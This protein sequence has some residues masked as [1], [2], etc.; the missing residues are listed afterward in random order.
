[1]EIQ[2]SEI[3]A[4][5]MNVVK[6]QIKYIVVIHVV[7]M[8]LFLKQITFEKI[9]LYC[10]YRSSCREI[11]S[12]SIKKKG[13]EYDTWLGSIFYKIKFLYYILVT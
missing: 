12:L 4:L 8:I 7:I 13:F 11:D 2:N 3:I 1:M 9:L 6:Q 5:Q 10:I